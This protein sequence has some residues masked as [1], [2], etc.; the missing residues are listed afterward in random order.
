VP[1]PDEL[2]EIPQV[3]TSKVA[4]VRSVTPGLGVPPDRVVVSRGP[5]ALD[6]SLQDAKDSRIVR[7]YATSTCVEHL[8]DSSATA[9]A[10]LLPEGSP[11]DLVTVVLVIAANPAT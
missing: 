1:L 11:M 6:L 2:G 7:V 8:D 10:G 9:H 5:K 4:P 3:S